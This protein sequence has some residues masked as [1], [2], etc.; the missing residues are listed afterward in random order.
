MH[1]FVP[2]K[3]LN[4]VCKMC[5]WYFP[6]YSFIYCIEAIVV[7]GVGETRYGHLHLWPLLCY[8][9]MNITMAVDKVLRNE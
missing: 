3:C 9:L 5:E 6:A 7:E 1:I 2:T 4:V 8:S